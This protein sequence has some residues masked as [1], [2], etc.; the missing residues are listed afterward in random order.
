MQRHVRPGHLVADMGS[1]SGILS[2]AAVRLGARKVVAMEND[3]DAAENATDNVLSN[4]VD[5]RVM[6]LEGDAATLL[7]LAAPFDVIVA[8]I[9]SSVLI[10]LLP[11]MRTS[12]ANCGIV[13]L[14]GILIDESADFRQVLESEGWL[15][16]DEETEGAWCALAIR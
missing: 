3:P 13:I 4:G 12:L 9:V 14:S 15:I 5:D 16:A 8:N 2:I 7:P 11:A 10:A 1:G 6:L